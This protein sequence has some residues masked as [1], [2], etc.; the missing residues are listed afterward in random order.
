MNQPKGAVSVYGYEKS[1]NKV[2]DKKEMNEIYKPCEKGVCV[3]TP[4]S[5]FIVVWS[6][7]IDPTTTIVPA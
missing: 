2:N 3:H 6:F 4:V 5:F 1:G 7:K